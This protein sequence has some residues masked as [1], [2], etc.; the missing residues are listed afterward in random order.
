M[1]R[2]KL[3]PPWVEYYRELNCLFEEDPEVTIIFDEEEPEVKLY[4]N[5]HLKAY[6]LT[7]LLPVEKEFGNVTL[8]VT[9]IPPNGTTGISNMKGVNIFRVA[10]KNN[11]I[12][13]YI[14]ELET[15]V[16]GNVTYVVFENKVAQYFI[17]NICDI[18]G[19][20]STLYQD[21]A[22]NVFEDG[23]YALDTKV[24]FCTD[25]PEGHSLYEVEW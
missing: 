6:A 11:P 7:E 10:F 25:V 4:V 9:V 19:V 5:N 1:A 8:K 20:R 18:H 12:V 24:F 3:S 23:A 2:I 22:K 21:I 17:D 14:E 15:I 16:M 13:S